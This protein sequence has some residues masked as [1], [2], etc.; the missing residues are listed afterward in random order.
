M[1]S[2]FKNL[3]FASAICLAATPLTSL[4]DG[5]ATTNGD[6]LIAFYELDGEVLG[7][8]TYVFNL[9]PQHLYRENT[10]NNALVST[11]NMSITS[12]NIADDLETAFGANWREE[13]KV[14][15]CVVGGLDQ[16]TMGFVNGERQ[17]TCYASRA[18]TNFV[19]VGATTARLDMAGATRNSFR[20]NYEAFRNGSNLSGTTGANT[21]GAIIPTTVVGSLEEYLP[22]QSPSN[23]QFG[24]G[25]EIRQSFTTGFVAGSVNLEGALD[26]WRLPGGTSTTELLGSGTDLTSGLGSPITALGQGQYIGTLT[27]D[28]N[29]DLRI[30]G[31]SSA[32]GSY[33]TWASTN[34][35]SGGENGDSDNDGIKNL[36]EYALALNPAASDGAPGTFVGGLLS[37]T[38][39][40]EAVTNGD[41]T[42]A[43]QESDDLG[44]T[45]PWSTV[46][47]TS[48]NPTTIS[49]QLPAGSPKKFARLLV[50][51]NS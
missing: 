18:V 6:L 5:V 34:N 49:Y 26:I 32:S 24:T 14:Q 48:N 44:V 8:N 46:T 17:Q 20:N 1:K 23:L 28:T 21:R 30:G 2:R 51:T 29:G 11:I 31:T 4:A 22:P 12:A 9:G 41:L 25:L 10:L 39:R 40:T 47:P 16:T 27:I 45:D 43:I 50:T 38:K 3:L 19:A 15:W 35:V 42:Y 36:V 13:G 7:D 33:S 37:F